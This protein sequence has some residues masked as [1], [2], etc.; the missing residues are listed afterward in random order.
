MTGAASQK[1]APHVAQGQLPPS[2]R[3]FVRRHLVTAAD[4]E[5]LLLVHRERRPWTP[6]AVA[7]ELRIHA[8]QA[9][10]ILSRLIASG[11][12]QQ[13]GDDYYYRPKEVGLTE[14]VEELVAFY[15][16]YRV[17]IISLIFADRSDSMRDFSEAFRLRDDE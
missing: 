2:L 6:T 13:D 7:K 3:T 15:P 5:V 10:G 1:G 4:L 9:R 12:V 11:L 16:A 8:D 14:A 17:A